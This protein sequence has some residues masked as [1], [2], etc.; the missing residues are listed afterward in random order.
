MKAI[1]VAI[2]LVVV[3]LLFTSCGRNENNEGYIPE[4]P[5][6]ND[7]PPPPPVPE[8]YEIDTS[9]EAEIPTTAPDAPTRY[10]PTYG[11]LHQPVDLGGRTVRIATSQ[12]GHTL[13]GFGDEP[14]PAIAANYL[15]MRRIW[16][17]AERVR[18]TFNIE[19]EEIYFFRDT[20]FLTVT[21]MSVVLNELRTSVAAGAPIADAALLFSQNKVPAILDEILVPL[22]SINLPNSDILGSQLFAE[23]VAELFGERWSFDSVTPNIGAV[24]L[25]VN[26]DVI[27]N[28]GAPNPVDLYHHGEW[29]WQNFLEIMRLANASNTGVFGICVRGGIIGGE[30]STML[31]AANDGR[32]VSEDF[33]WDLLYPNTLEA[34]EFAELLYYE[35]LVS[36]SWNFDHA[37]SNA[38]FFS[39]NAH[40]L[41]MSNISYEHTVLPMPIGPSNTS[42]TVA[43][44]GWSH[45]GFVLPQGSSWDPAEVLMIMEELHA[46]PGEVELLFE[47]AL[48]WFAENIPIDDFE[49]VLSAGRNSVFCVSWIIPDLQLSIM[50][51]FESALH[52]GAMTL[53]DIIEH[54]RAPHQAI[55]DEFFRVEGN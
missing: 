23:T 29:N 32:L 40:S 51:N 25:G 5:A 17:N 1:I 42:G 36:H 11:V 7:I 13:F 43:T 39:T 50:N 10:I 8:P 9:I 4:Y 31:I 18:H 55:L 49:R 27:N 21:D 45:G 47:L 41:V 53:F 44:H 38:A 16:N 28:I 34:L 26:L 3:A 12:A 20:P 37:R 48:G 2:A 35:S 22:D 46:W 33:E 15:A 14:D 19:F 24:M 6:E 30:I 52:R 54:H